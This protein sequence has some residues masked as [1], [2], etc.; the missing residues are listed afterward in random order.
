MR[1]AE[2]L[3][4]DEKAGVLIQTDDGSFTFSYS[5]E[6]ISISNKPSISPTLPKNRKEF[7]SSFLFPFFYNMLPEGSNKQSI[8]KYYKIDEDDYF[9]ILMITAKV[10]SIGAVRV[11]KIETT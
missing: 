7:N 11:R 1:K 6:W 4:K 8:C 3:Y 9:G 5:D 2:V 10:D